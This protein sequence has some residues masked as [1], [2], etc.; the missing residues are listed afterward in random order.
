M[1]SGVTAEED[2]VVMLPRT[3]THEPSVAFHIETGSS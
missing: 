3:G 2:A 1:T